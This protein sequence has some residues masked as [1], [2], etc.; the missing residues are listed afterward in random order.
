MLISYKKHFWNNM[1]I[2]FRMH[3][4]RVLVHKILRYKCLDYIKS[5]SYDIQDVT[6]R[7]KIVIKLDNQK[8]IFLNLLT[9]I[10]YYFKDCYIRKQT[11]EIIHK[12]TF[13]S[14]VNFDK[15]MMLTC[16]KAQK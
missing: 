3:K 2:S 13:I 11:F 8:V 7:A 16:L 5:E 15:I 4:I 6:L 14:T 1:N 9:S 10:K 12:Y